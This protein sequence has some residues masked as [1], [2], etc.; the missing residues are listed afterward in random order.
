MTDCQVEALENALEAYDKEYIKYKIEGGVSIG[1][2]D[3]ETLVAGLDARMTAFR[4]LYV[5]TVYVHEKYRRMGY[6]RQ[7]MEEMEKRAKA[8][9]ANTIRL[10]T[11]SWQ[12]K[13][14]YLAMGYEQV[15]YYSNLEDGYE[16]YFFMKRI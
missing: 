5:S 3:G 14:F 1:L 7:L 11:F 9:G 16:E 4:I 2:L 15:G 13:E 12:G 8:L 6:G 10:D